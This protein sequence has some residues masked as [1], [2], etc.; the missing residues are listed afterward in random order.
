MRCAIPFIAAS[1]A[2]LVLSSCSKSIGPAD[3][4]KVFF[5]HVKAGRTAE[6]YMS[7]AFAFQAQ[8][9]QKFFERKLKE[10]GLSDIASADYEPAEMEDGGRSAKVRADFKTAAGTSVPLVITLVHESGAWKVFGI[11]SP[12]D[13]ITGLVANRFT[14][15]GQGPDFVEPVNRQAPP[16]LESAEL[17]VGETLLRFNAAIKDRD[18]VPFFEQCS[19]AWQDQLVT[20]EFK[21]GT[22]MTMRVALTGREKEI[23]ASRLHRAFQPFIDK[24]VDLSGVTTRKPIFDGPPQVTTDGL[25]VVTG[26]YPTEPYRVAF[27][28]KFMYEL[29]KW[30][31]FGLDVS[32]RK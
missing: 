26:H 16:S 11:M 18:F 24:E 6:A 28:M 22:P 25:M 14:V 31:L 21:P 7:S 30:K 17:L 5:D 29:P 2:A 12:R 15:V 3:A 4:T 23:G 10:V 32:L 27:S 9:S 13:A 19:L 8:Q 20:G 1:V